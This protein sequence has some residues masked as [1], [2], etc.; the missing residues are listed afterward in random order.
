MLEQR[1][2]GWGPCPATSRAGAAAAAFPCLLSPRAC[3]PGSTG[4]MAH[5]SPVS[6]FPDVFSARFPFMHAACALS[7]HLVLQG[8]R[9]DRRDATFFSCRRS[10]ACIGCVHLGSFGSITVSPVALT[11][12]TPSG[13]PPSVCSH[14]SVLLPIPG[15][16]GFTSQA[17]GCSSPSPFM[18]RAVPGRGEGGL[19]FA[20]A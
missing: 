4:P 16:H 2:Q 14:I 11:C 13:P 1:G 12:S 10:Q 7:W 3:L 8:T 19:L 20:L 5:Q 15:R 6:N 18:G 17:C 9:W